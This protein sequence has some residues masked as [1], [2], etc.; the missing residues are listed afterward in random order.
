MAMDIFSEEVKKYDVEYF[1]GG[2]TSYQYRATI[3]LRRADGS[4]IGVA[5]F[6][7]DPATMPNTDQRDPQTG[8]V[9]CNY[10][11]DS[12]SQ[13]LDLLRNEKPVWV[14]YAGG[15]LRIGSITVW[16]PVGEG[17]VPAPGEG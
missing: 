8:F 17:E 6:H 3:G 12:F 10:P 11:W 9:R 16:E 7:R 4:P 1:G 5:Y 14:H 13:V 2:K 15:Q